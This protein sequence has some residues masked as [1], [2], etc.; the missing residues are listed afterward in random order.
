MRVIVVGSQGLVGQ[1]LKPRLKAA[2]FEVM[3]LDV[4]AA[5]P[6]HLDITQAEAARSLIPG[7]APT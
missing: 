4:V 6:F 1:Y 5:P 7:L 2:G 3:G